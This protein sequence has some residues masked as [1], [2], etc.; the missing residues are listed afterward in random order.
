M[1]KQHGV[2]QLVNDI[3]SLCELQFELLAVDGKKAIEKGVIGLLTTVV[4]FAFAIAS[5]TVLL[6]ACVWFV[7][8]A[9]D[10]SLGWSLLTAGMIGFIVSAALL[11]VSFRT[12]KSAVAAMG[13][14]RSELSQNIKWLKASLL[15][16]HLPMN[17]TDDDFSLEPEEMLGQVHSNRQSRSFR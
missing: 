8:V 7:H 1:P 16:N 10:L 15:Q 4:A 12:V 11:W 5:L 9:A 14:T 2:T 6:G 3:V 13:E 17:Q